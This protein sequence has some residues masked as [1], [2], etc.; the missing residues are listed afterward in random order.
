M[1]VETKMSLPGVGGEICWWC[2]LSKVSGFKVLAA[3]TCKHC[4]K[5]CLATAA[6]DKIHWKWMWCSDY[7][8]LVLAAAPW[9]SL[10]KGWAKLA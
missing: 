4:L 8:W 3:P 1:L 9:D 5:A 7:C 2:R 10:G 6:A